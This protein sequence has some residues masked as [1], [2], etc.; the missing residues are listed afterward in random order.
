MWKL[1]I[2]YLNGVKKLKVLRMDCWQNVLYLLRASQLFI[3]MEL[4]DIAI[5]GPYLFYWN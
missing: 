3:N 2:T 4:S 5:L 1:L